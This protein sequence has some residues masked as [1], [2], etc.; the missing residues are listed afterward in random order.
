MLVDLTQLQ[1]KCHPETETIDITR[2]VSIKERYNDI[3]VWF[4]GKSASIYHKEVKW[5]HHTIMMFPDLS[6]PSSLSHAILIW[7]KHLMGNKAKPPQNHNIPA[8][9]SPHSNEITGSQQEP[10]HSTNEYG[11]TEDEM[12]IGGITL[13]TIALD[14]IA[15]SSA[16]E[17][18][19]ND[20]NVDE[21][22]EP[23][24]ED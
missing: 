17:C 9:T 11:L 16:E 3:V 18:V 7:R 24:Q 2:I 21:A 15:D 4:G 12:I 10:H 19:D 6:K 22:Y 14:T 1:D 13:G 23:D 8:P 20:V 5:N